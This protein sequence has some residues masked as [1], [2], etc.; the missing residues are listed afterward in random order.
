MTVFLL[1]L[2]LESHLFSPLNQSA[3]LLHFFSALIIV[4]HGSNLWNS[5]KYQGVANVNLR[6]MT[7]PCLCLEYR[8]KIFQHLGWGNIFSRRNL[9][10]VHKV[11]LSQ[12]VKLCS[13]SDSKP[14]SWIMRS[15]GG[16]Q[17]GEYKFKK[18]RLFEGR[19]SG[20]LYDYCVELNL[21]YLSFIQAWMLLWYGWL[22]LKSDKFPF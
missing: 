4:W 2:V 5:L 12:A 17:Q 13:E 7:P 15:K 19:S 14:G 18:C 20:P 6:K 16:L 3:L 22:G 1:D 8:R 11:S 21:T 10:F 9:N